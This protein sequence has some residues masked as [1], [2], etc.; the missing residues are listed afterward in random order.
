MVVLPGIGRGIIIAR[1]RRVTKNMLDAAAKAVA[2]KANPT[3][4][5][6]GAPARDVKDLRVISTAVAVA[7]YHAAV[8]DGVAT[9]S[10]EKLPWAILDTMWV[11]EYQPGEEK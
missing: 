1:A 10:H 2:R 4:P 7:A 5:G 3:A 8:E 11:P 6:A 9:N